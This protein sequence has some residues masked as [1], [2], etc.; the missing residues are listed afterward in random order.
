MPHDPTVP[1]V[2]PFT[3]SGR[4]EDWEPTARRL[5]IGGRVLVVAAS[6]LLIGLAAGVKIVA[7]GHQ[8]P[9]PTAPW[10]VTQFTLC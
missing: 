2:I 9:D 10:I 5:K 6:V 4:V 7:S 3:I 8:Q 1:E